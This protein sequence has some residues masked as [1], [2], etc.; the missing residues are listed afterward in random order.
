MYD[1]FLY[2]EVNE[3][4]FIYSEQITMSMCYIGTIYEFNITEQQIDHNWTTVLNTNMYHLIYALSEIACSLAILDR[5][6]LTIS[7]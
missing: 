2:W 3:E 1:A 4:I 6:I 7:K 5:N